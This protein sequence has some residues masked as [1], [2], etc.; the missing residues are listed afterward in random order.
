MVKCT[1]CDNLGPDGW[2]KKKGWS[3]FSNKTDV[4]CKDFDLSHHKWT[5]RWIN[6]LISIET[7]LSKTFEDW[8]KGFEHRYTK[9][10]LGI[11]KRCWD[12]RRYSEDKK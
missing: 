4:D 9:Q 7:I 2:C 6:E 5:E 10:D 11:M 1:D 8:I 12:T 3:E